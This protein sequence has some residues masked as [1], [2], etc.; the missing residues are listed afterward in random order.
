MIC[1]APIQVVKHSDRFA[2]ICMGI[3]TKFYTFDN[4]GLKNI[5]I[6]YFPKYNN[7]SSTVYEN[8]TYHNENG[9]KDA[10]RE[11]IYN[12]FDSGYTIMLQ[13]HI[14]LFKWFDA[15]M[16]KEFIYDRRFMLE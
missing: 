11:R 6:V 8:I 3:P 9:Q 16:L 1:R 10:F 7:E 2:V 15:V 4:G 5:S 12:L 14:E 13:N